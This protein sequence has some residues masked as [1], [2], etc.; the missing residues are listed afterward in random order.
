M[1]LEIKSKRNGFSSDAGGGRAL[2][3][4]ST[5]HVSGKAALRVLPE[6]KV[7]PNPQWV[8]PHNWT[9]S[10]SPAGDSPIQAATP[11]SAVLAHSLPPLSPVT[12]VGSQSLSP[13]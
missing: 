4:P 5:S 12:A 13:S 1:G 8:S 9:T 11:G 6:G 10:G 3:T 7:I 2:Q